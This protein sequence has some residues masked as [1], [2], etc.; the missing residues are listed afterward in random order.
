MAPD[1]LVARLRDAGAEVSLA[2]LDAVI[3]GG[4]AAPTGHGAPAG[5]ATDARNGP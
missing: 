1:E 2:D 3:D 4:N 5:G